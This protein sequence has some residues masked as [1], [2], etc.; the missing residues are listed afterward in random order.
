MVQSSAQRRQ[1]TPQARQSNTL[2]DPDPTAVVQFDLD[3]A[4]CG[5][6]RLLRRPLQIQCARHL[7]RQKQPGT[8]FRQHAFANLAPP[9]KE[10]AG[11][12][13][14]AGS[15]I[16]DPSAWLVCLRNDPQLLFDRPTA[17]TL[18]TDNDLYDPIRHGSNHTSTL[19]L[20]CP[21]PF[22]EPRTGDPERTH[23]EL[24]QKPVLKAIP[25]SS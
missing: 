17:A 23:T 5:R 9:R 10:Q 21:A 14:M 22:T 7:D 3:P 4:P 16:A 25:V 20:R 24:R 15:D 18:T 12:D 13:V 8:A 6:F 2:V 1:N 19:A 11:I